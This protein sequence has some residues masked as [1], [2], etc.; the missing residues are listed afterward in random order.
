MKHFNFTTPQPT[1]ALS[2]PLAAALSLSLCLGLAQVQAAPPTPANP[3]LLDYVRTR[4]F[5][6]QGGGPFEIA[7]PPPTVMVGLRA[8]HGAWIDA[9]GP[10]CAKYVNGR[11]LAEVSYRQ[12]AGGDGGGPGEMVCQ[13]PRGVVTGLQMYQADN[14]DGSVGRIVIE[15]GDYLNPAKFNHILHGSALQLGQSMRGQRNIIRCKPP[16]VAGGI[17]G[18]R[19][20]FVDRLGMTCVDYQPRR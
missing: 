16:M 15:C 11:V 1:R 8:R 13:G 3:D 6:G 20:A 9:V 12:L 18:R 5:G 17:F 19:G 14:E 4:S 10:I 2:K 7:C